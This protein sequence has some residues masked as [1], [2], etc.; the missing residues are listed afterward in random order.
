MSILAHRPLLWLDLRQNVV[1]GARLALFMPVRALDFRV[2]GPDYAM[3]VVT[4]LACWAAGSLARVGT[5]A[6][7][8]V[9]AVTVALAQIPITLLACLALAWIFGRPQLVLAF[10][11]LLTASDPLFEVVSVAAHYLGGFDLPDLYA[12]IANWI[13]MAWGLAV[14]A[15]AQWLLTGWRG[16]RSLA[17]AV[18]LAALVACLLWVLPRTELWAEP[19][20]QAPATSAITREDVF[21]FQGQILDA[22]LNDLAAERPGVEDLYF[23]GVAAYGLQDT[24]AKE[25]G[26]VRQLMDERFDTAG[27]SIALINHPATLQSVPI[28]TATNLRTT[29]E[30]L[31]E[32]INVDED[33][34]MLHLTTHGS[35]SHE[36]AF[37]LPPLEL[38]ALTPTALA[39]MLADSGIKWKIIVISACY[40]G[41]FIEPLRDDNSL[42]ITAAD[43]LHSS[44]GCDYDSDITWFSKAFYDQGLRQTY[45]FAEAFKRA[46]QAVAAWE[47]ADGLEPSNPQI[48]VGAAMREK[49][50]SLERRLSTLRAAPRVTA[51]VNVRR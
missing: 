43:A 7:I 46:K 10:A 39:R 48:F 4:S 37:E 32:N 26:L 45:S 35:E 13:V 18:V 47:R 33:V 16:L 27:R 17:A 14:I 49:L 21:H 29:L 38:Q 44:F 22:Q 9:H 51:S 3:L 15:R 5:P 28:A 36:L 6:A 41:G 34:V 31:G 1:A 23:V 12:S 30:Y 24:F 50:A 11:V 25:L 42:I 20:E 40:S 2:S 19:P 8:D